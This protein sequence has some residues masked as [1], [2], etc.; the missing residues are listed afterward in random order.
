MGPGLSGSMPAGGGAQRSEG[1]GVDGEASHALDALRLHVKVTE[2]QG[3][4]SHSGARHKRAVR[5]PPSAVC[6]EESR[7]E[8]VCSMD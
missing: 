2:R 1:A 6:T 5:R 7:A 8:A 4:I 3:R